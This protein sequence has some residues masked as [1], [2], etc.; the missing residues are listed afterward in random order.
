MRATG[1]LIAA[2]AALAAAA[3]GCGGGGER[4]SK[5]ELVQRADA[6]CGKYE[7][8]FES[9][10]VP[11]GDPTAPDAPRRL[12]RQAAEAGPA[13]ARIERQ[14]VGELRGL[15]PPEELAERWDTALDGLETRADQ[16][17][18]VGRSAGAGDREGLARAFAA[19]DQAGTRADQ[20][21]RGFG[22]RRCGSGS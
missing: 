1:A 8:R 4:L 18:A 13:I 20:A 22:F 5:A 9:V 16:L 11:E 2:G 19:A 21:V 10:A 17:D 12:L 15:E 14:Q 7:A 6:I 3:A